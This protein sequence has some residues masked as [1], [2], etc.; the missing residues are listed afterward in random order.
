MQKLNTSSWLSIGFAL[1]VVFLTGCSHY[2]DVSDSSPTTALLSGKITS[3]E[4]FKSVEQ[5][6]LAQQEQEQFEFN[7][8]P[9]RAY[10]TKTGKFEFVPKDSQQ[11][12]NENTKRWEFTPV[13]KK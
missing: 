10:N 1:S 11:K 12:W 6:N 4:Y 3:K 5:A 13:V 9:T 8:E 7:R 2:Q